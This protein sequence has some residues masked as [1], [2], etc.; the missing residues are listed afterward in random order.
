M[1]LQK[2]IQSDPALNVRKTKAITLGGQS[3][4][5]DIAIEAKKILANQIGKASSISK[6]HDDVDPK[7]LGAETQF[8]AP[9]AVTARPSVG[10]TNVEA[11]RRE[12]SSV[13]PEGQPVLY[14]A[15]VTS[16]KKIKTASLE[17]ATISKTKKQPAMVHP[18][19]TRVVAA[20]RAVQKQQAHHK[21]P[22]KRKAAANGVHI[23]T[24]NVTVAS[25]PAAQ[26]LPVPAPT[27]APTHIAKSV[28]AAGPSLNRTYMKRF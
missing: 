27:P 6:H 11:R 20:K 24:I 23:G 3:E 2:N 26:P 4:T 17:S 10:A 14:G 28:P 9:Q 19:D 18:N 25:P 15:A 13:L 16:D 22:G 7:S 5:A 8:S 21:K 1:T 12:V